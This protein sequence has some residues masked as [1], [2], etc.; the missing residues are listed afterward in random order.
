MPTLYKQF[1]AS[2]PEL[3]SRY[4]QNKGHEERRDSFVYTAYFYAGRPE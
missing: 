4:S 1:S 3:E 2:L